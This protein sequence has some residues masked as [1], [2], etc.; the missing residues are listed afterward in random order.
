[1]SIP[2]SDNSGSHHEQIAFIG[3]GNMASAIM[4][5]LLKRGLA[6]TIQEWLMSAEYI[7]ANGNYNV[8]L[9]ERGIRTFETATRFTL[10]L[11]AVPVLKHLSHLPV[12]VDPSHGVGIVNILAKPRNIDQAVI[13]KDIRQSVADH[14]GIVAVVRGKS[15]QELEILLP[16][17][18]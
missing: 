17:H 8:I 7:M 1:M 4:G 5:G 9:C 11:N 13:E 3:G 10:D 6:T 18:A 14:F 12:V 2:T 15:S 16:H